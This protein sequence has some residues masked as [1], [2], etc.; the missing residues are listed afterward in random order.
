[1]ACLPCEGEAT[2]VTPG[3][4]ATDTSDVPYTVPKPPLL[5]LKPMSRSTVFEYF[6]EYES[7]LGRYDHID[8]EGVEHLFDALLKVGFYRAHRITTLKVRIVS[9]FFWEIAIEL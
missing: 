1:M 5:P 8:E 9:N 2:C 3:S 4:S 6:N 7:F